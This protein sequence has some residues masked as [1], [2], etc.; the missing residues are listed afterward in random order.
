[1]ANRYSVGGDGAAT[2][3]T[4]DQS[5]AHLW[6]PHAT[7]SIYIR[8]VHCFST[9]A[10]AQ[11]PALVRTTSA[12]TTP[13]TTVT[14]DADNAWDRRAVPPSGCILYL[15]TFA[16]YPT[17]ATPY[18]ARTH[19]PAAIGAAVMWSFLDEPIEVPAGTGLGVT[20]PIA[21]A[22]QANRYSFVWDE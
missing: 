14:P 5:G 12:G 4:A 8:E 21:T 16:T 7:K 10:T 6:N 22:L 1:M 20:T 17:V 9:A 3:A 19:L 18:L 13:G 15:A 11:A 2:A